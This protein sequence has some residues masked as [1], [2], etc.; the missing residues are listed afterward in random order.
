M[1]SIKDNIELRSDKVRSIIGQIPPWLIRSGM[2]V[3]LLVFVALLVGS[4]HFKYPYTITST[5]QFSQVDNSFVGVV[6]IPANEISKV[7]KGQKVE[8]YFDDIKNLNGLMFNSKI[9]EISNKVTITDEKGFYKA[10]IDKVENLI[11]TEKANGIAKITTDEIS[12]FERIIKPFKILQ[13]NSDI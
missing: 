4:Y 5:V 12:F 3:I 1:E 11:I 8:I 13:K 10:K 6:N 7:E 9:N 2:S